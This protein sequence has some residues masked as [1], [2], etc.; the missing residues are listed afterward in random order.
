MFNTWE[1][2]QVV[3][4]LTSPQA[5]RAFIVIVFSA[6]ALTRVMQ[7]ESVP[8]FMVGVLGAFVGYYFAKSQD[9]PNRKN[10]P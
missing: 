8:E 2:P 6:V 7:G 9:T 5:M 10:S 4:D 1:I 3:Y